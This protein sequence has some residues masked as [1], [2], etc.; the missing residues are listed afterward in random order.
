MSNE[1]ALGPIFLAMLLDAHLCLTKC[2]VMNERETARDGMTDIS[3]LPLNLKTRFVQI[4]ERK[5]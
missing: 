3:Y 1:L 2:I 5:Y 4:Y